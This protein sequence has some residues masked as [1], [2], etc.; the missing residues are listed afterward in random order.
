MKKRIRLD[1]ETRNAIITGLVAMSPLKNRAQLLARYK[2]TRDRFLT[3]F[4]VEKS[5]KKYA[6]MNG[7]NAGANGDHHDLYIAMDVV[8]DY[9]ERC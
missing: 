4:L 8:K 1:K 2:R 5:P 6:L 3:S 9:L 7:F